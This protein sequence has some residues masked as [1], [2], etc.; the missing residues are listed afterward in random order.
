MILTVAAIVALVGLLMY[1][2]CASQK[3]QYIGL[4]MFGVGL[5]AAL[6]NVGTAIHLLPTGR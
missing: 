4:V 1:V 5:L 6:M 2:L 3:L